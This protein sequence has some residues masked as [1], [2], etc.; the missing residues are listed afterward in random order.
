[1]NMPAEDITLIP[2][3]SARSRISAFPAIN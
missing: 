2:I 3:G 1:L